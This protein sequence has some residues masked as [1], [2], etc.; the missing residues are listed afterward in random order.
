MPVHCEFD[1]T[2]RTLNFPRPF[3]DCPRLAHGIRELDI[4]KDA[5]IRVTSTLQHLT[6]SSVDC[7][8]TT[9]ADSTLHS[10]V[11]DVLALAPYDLDFLTGEHMRSLWKNPSDPASVRINFERP[12]VTPPKVVVFFNCIN[13]Y[14]RRGNWRLKTTATDIDVEGFTLNIETWSDTA[15]SAARACWLAYP[16]DR[17]HI[18]STSVNTR[19]I[20]PANQPQHQHS[21]EIL[22][23]SVEFIKK[24]SV[25]IALNSLDISNNANL[26]INAYVDGI[27]TTRLVWHIDSWADT[28]LYS[29][30]A[31]I[32]AFD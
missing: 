14:M 25:F 2:Q 13:L 24:P 6:R 29:A 19:D 12:F 28:T 7:H 15:F 10:A 22:F 30:G 1:I 20:R 16:E 23:N 11:A 3:V 4:G 27:S 8:I 5:G 9:W 17:G 32:I 18:F 31:T 21:K 26:R